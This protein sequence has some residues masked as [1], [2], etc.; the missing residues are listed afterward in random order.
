MQRANRSTCD[1]HVRG[2][3]SLNQD[4]LLKMK[5]FFDRGIACKVGAL[6]ILIIAHNGLAMPLEA[7]VLHT[8]R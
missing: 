5:V 7:P 6:E 4:V 3:T 8:V 2:E 1:P